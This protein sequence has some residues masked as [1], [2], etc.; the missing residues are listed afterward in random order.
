VAGEY[1]NY[2]HRKLSVLMMS[3]KIGIAVRS[4]VSFG[5][6]VVLLGRYTYGAGVARCGKAS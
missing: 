3:F 4:P 5:A 2:I 1:I 6:C